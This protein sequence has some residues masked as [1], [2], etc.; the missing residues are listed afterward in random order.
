M[1][2]LFDARDVFPGGQGQFLPGGDAG[3]V[4]FPA[5]HGFVDRLHV[6]QGAFVLGRVFE[7]LAFVAV[8]DADFDFVEAA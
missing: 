3:D 2:G 5:G 1:Q 4:F 7:D 8:A 6:F